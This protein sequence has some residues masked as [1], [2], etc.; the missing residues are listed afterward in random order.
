MGRTV[1]PVRHR[2]LRTKVEDKSVDYGVLKS[3][4]RD[5]VDLQVKRQVKALIQPL[6]QVVMSDPNWQSQMTSLPQ[7]A[8]D[9]LDSEIGETEDADILNNTD[10]DLWR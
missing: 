5:E 2:K 8:R 4:I 6:Y 9:L 3:L 1:I 10:E 7:W